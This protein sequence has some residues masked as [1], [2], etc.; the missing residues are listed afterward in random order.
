MLAG[1]GQTVWNQL[2]RTGTVDSMGR[3]N[4]FKEEPQ[5]GRAINKALKE[6]GAW[7]NSLPEETDETDEATPIKE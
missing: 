5:I 6:A 7:S 3:E 4:I 2:Y 1:V